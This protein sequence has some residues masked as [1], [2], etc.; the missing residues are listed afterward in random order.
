[1]ER[2]SV[3]GLELSQEAVSDAARTVHFSGKVEYVSAIAEMFSSE[4]LSARSSTIHKIHVA[5]R[6]GDKK[7]ALHAGRSVAGKSYTAEG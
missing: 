1:M 6:D 5:H 7:N 3:V 4:A 2:I